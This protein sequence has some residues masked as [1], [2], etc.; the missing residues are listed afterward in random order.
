VTYP[1]GRIERLLSRINVYPCRCQLCTNR[2]RVF[3][4]G[5]RHSTQAFDRRQYIR[6]PASIEVQV[7]D[8]KQL[9]VT[10]RITEI[11]M[12]GCTLQTTG[13][14]KGSFIG[15]VLKP[16][17]E[18]E[19]IHVETAM[20]CSVRPLS[21]GVRFLE[22]QPEHYRRLAQVVLGLLVGQGFVTGPI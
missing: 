12:D 2:F 1:E 15:L 6:L 4:A 18:E 5:A 22:I 8:H 11:S 14:P 7:L 16:M 9:P 13:F 10:N 3:H 19:A 21:M 20:V 17:V